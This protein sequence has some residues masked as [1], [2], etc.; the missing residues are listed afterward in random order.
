[1][2]ALDAD[3]VDIEYEYSEVLSYYAL[4]KTYED[5]ED[6]R[7]DRAKRQYELLLREWKAYKSKS[8]DEIKGRI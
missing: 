4:W 8:V 2:A 7:A 1:L 3:I 6:D 5:R